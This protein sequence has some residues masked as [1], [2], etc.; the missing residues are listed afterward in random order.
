MAEH[1]KRMQMLA[2][3]WREGIITDE[4]KEEF[5]K[6]YSSFDD[7]QAELYTDDNQEVMKERLYN[8]ILQQAEIRTGEATIYPLWRKMIVAASVV[9]ALGIGGWL[10][11]HKQVPGNMTGNNHKNL[12]MPG[13][14]QAMLV[15]ANGKKIEL[16][17]VKNGVLAKQGVV[18]VKKTANG[19][20]A[21][22]GNDQTLSS[23]EENIL[24]TPRGGQYH[25]TLGDGT[26][27]WLD[28]AS[29]IRF[30]V[31]F[32][33][34][35]RKVQITG[36]AYFE[37]AKDK[38]HPFIVTAGNQTV[39]VLGTHFNINSYVDEPSIRTTLLEG[40]VKVTNTKTGET[41]TLIPGQQSILN[42]DKLSVKEAD[43]EEAIAWKNGYFV[44]NDESIS[45]IM[46]KLSRWYD[47]DI[48]YNG[49]VPTDKFEG[50]VNRFASVQQVLKKLELT[51]RV[52]FKIEERRIMVS[53]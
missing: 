11:L 6:W 12:I 52:H 14:N 36:E 48:V 19:Q 26:Q 49:P 32:T 35:S 21:Y 7:T 17:N 15:L 8:K 13:S 44:F 25:L 23:S 16:N 30:P 10:L 3:R 34:D 29:S 47:V 22:S 37:V 38:A 51:D 20:L 4:E 31:S 53:Q 45:S 9:A 39:Q 43:T 41:G 40:S 1:N 18:D 50:T 27:V 33:G 42:N 5:E 46:R 2:K 28:A 24:E